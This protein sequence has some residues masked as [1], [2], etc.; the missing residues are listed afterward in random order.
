MSQLMALSI[1]DCDISLPYH[2]KDPCVTLDH[3]L[4]LYVQTLNICLSGSRTINALKILSRFIDFNYSQIIWFLC[5]RRN[6][7]KLAKNM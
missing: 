4:N 5:G 2:L 7:T 3:T 1:Q 6:G